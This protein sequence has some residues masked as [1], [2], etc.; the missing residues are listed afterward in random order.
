MEMGE[1]GAQIL[2]KEIAYFRLK[3]LIN[4]NTIVRK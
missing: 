1:S 2:K 3:S 4:K